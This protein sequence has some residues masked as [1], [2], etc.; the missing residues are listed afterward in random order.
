MMKQKR[1]RAGSPVSVEEE[2][3]IY[4]EL[5]QTPIGEDTELIGTIEDYLIYAFGKH[6]G[7]GGQFRSRIIFAVKVDVM[8]FPMLELCP[9]RWFAPSIVKLFG[10]K[11]WERF[12]QTTSFTPRK[13]WTSLTTIKRQLQYW[14]EHPKKA[15]Y[16]SVYIDGR[17]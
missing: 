17:K 13:Y 2:R 15:R 8:Q 1:K 5:E 6:D 10:W 3:A 11:D 14:R 12:K 7:H 16:R 9:R 4:K